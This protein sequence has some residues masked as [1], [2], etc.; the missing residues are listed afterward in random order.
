MCIRDRS[1]CAMRLTVLITIS[2]MQH[3]ATDGVAWSVCVCVCAYVMG[4]ITAKRLNRSRCR[5]ARIVP[6]NHVLHGGS[7]SPR[8]RTI[9]GV[10]KHGHA[11]SVYI[12]AWIFGVT[13]RRFI[14]L[15]RSLVV[16]D[17]VRTAERKPKQRHP[18]AAK[19]AEGSYHYQP[20]PFQRR[21]RGGDTMC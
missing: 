14:E 7:G 12:G 9:L 13:M 10:G 17:A 3:I 4:I 5:L 16:L 6:H 11:R 1:K 15:L 2:L 18:V 20:R 8:E 21:K 19:Q